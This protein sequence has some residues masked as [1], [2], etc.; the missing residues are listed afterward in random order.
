MRFLL[1]S[2]KFQL[3]F[4]ASAW[5][6]G[7]WKQLLLTQITA[8]AEHV[9]PEGS[10]PL[11]ALFIHLGLSWDLMLNS[12]KLL[13]LPTA[14]PGSVLPSCPFG[15]LALQPVALCLLGRFPSCP[16]PALVLLNLYLIVFRPFLRFVNIISNSSLV[17]PGTRSLPPSSECSTWAL[18]QVP[19]DQHSP[20]WGA[21]GLAGETPVS[22]CVGKPLADSPIL[23]LACTV[24]SEISSGAQGIVL[25][26]TVSIISKDWMR[27][28]ERANRLKLPGEGADESQ[29]TP[30]SP[31]M[32]L[33][34]PR[35]QALSH[36]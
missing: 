26:L 9:L 19:D 5:L 2:P 27:D 29:Y 21:R 36:R 18:C 4:Q 35:V 12:D 32:W 17:F 14:E 7:I 33:H 1:F 23:W 3:L 31:P 22:Q 25:L 8:P 24:A 30:Q 16:S 28:H 6:L 13:L 20:G 11:H 15:S 34:D 10:T